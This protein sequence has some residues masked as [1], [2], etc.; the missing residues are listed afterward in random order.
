ML[1]NHIKNKNVKS[2]D[3]NE[4]ASNHWQCT[5]H[6]ERADQVKKSE[7]NSGGETEYD[8]T[9]FQA[10]RNQCKSF[11]N[12]MKSWQSYLQHC[13]FISICSDDNTV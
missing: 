8:A 4:F 12:N 5:S 7:I 13:E 11:L 10:G 6:S 3:D 1:E 9:V 2:A